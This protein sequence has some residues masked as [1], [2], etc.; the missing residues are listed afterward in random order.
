M[1]PTQMFSFEIG[2]VFLWTVSFTEHLQWLLL[3]SFQKNNVIF[4]VIMTTLGY[5]QKFTWKYCNYYHPYK[6]ISI[7][8]QKH[9]RHLVQ[10]CCTLS[11][12]SPNFMTLSSI[13]DF[14]IFKG[15]GVSHTNT[16]HLIVSVSTVS[17]PITQR[18]N[19]LQ[20]KKCSWNY[21]LFI[22]IYL[23]FIMSIKT[24]AM[25]SFKGYINRYF[26]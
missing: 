10:K 23:K 21:S 26:V 9:G 15:D 16:V 24:S 12:Q 20:S 22:K 13:Y 7:F 6:K 5:N 17:C 1:T 25:Q 3:W 8:Y 4:G 18:R 11:R 19:S 2:E 14:N